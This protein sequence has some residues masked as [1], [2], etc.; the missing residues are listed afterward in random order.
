MSGLP[1]FLPP[2]VN[3]EIVQFAALTCSSDAH[4]GIPPINFF[5]VNGESDIGL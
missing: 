4:N 1:S 3:C 5:L 2:D